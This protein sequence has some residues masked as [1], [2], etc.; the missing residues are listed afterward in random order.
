[1]NDDLNSLGYV[2]LELLLSP[3][4]YPDDAH[5]APTPARVGRRLK[6]LVYDIFDCDILKLRDYCA[7]E[8]AWT[9]SSDYWTLRTAGVFGTAL[10]RTMKAGDAGAADGAGSSWL[11]FPNV[12]VVSFYRTRGARWYRAGSRCECIRSSHRRAFDLMPHPRR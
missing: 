7:N 12:V 9:A 8:E 2:L 4:L 11:N 3:A 6:T 1:M 10:A 5:Y